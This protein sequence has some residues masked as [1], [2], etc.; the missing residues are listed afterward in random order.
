MYDC[1]VYVMCSARQC[2][3][4]GAVVAVCGSPD[5][6][7]PTPQHPNLRRPHSAGAWLVEVGGATA[8]QSNRQTT[9]VTSSSS[10]SSD[11]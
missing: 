8:R 1:V 6:D 4:I 11:L 3:W 9:L 10:S 2:R 7:Q 5:V